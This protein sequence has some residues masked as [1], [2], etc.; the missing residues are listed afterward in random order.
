MN[1][2]LSK[3]MEIAFE[4]EEIN[5]KGPASSLDISIPEGVAQE[6]NSIR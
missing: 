6:E 1:E 3:K 4:R 2:M 5:T